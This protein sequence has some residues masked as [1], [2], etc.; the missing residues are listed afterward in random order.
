MFHVSS[1]EPLL[2]GKSKKNK[3]K[4]KRRKRKEKERIG[5]IGETKALSKH[6]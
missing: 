4:R 2:E 1:F 3:E 6:T 5:V